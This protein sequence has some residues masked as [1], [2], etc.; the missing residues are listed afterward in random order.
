MHDAHAWFLDARLAKL[1]AL[2]WM[3]A[4]IVYGFWRSRG[5]AAQ[6]VIRESGPIF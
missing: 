4:V 3:V 2:A 5:A 1:L 6:D